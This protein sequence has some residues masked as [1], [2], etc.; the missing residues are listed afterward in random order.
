MI[1]LRTD[2]FYDKKLVFEI[3]YN[4][5]TYDEL[6]CLLAPGNFVGRDVNKTFRI[7]RPS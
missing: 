1:F 6:W 2:A 3:L 5:S 4:D 7:K